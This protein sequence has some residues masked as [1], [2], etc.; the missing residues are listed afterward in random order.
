MREWGDGNGAF[1]SG[2]RGMQLRSLV[3]VSLLMGTVL[4]ASAEKATVA[5]LEQIIAENAA[6]TRPAIQHSMDSDEIADIADSNFLSDDDGRLAL[7]LAGIELEE[8]LST[9]SLYRL[10]GRYRLGS[11]AQMALQQIADRSAL[12]KLPPSEQMA[13]AA[14]DDEAQ[15]A[16]LNAAR[17]YVFGKLSHLP[18]FVATRTTTTFVDA[19]TPLRLSSPEAAEF[20]RSDMVQQEITFRD[21]KEVLLPATGALKG[22]SAETSTAFESRGEFG[23]QA[24]V[25]LMDVQ[26]G[27]ISFDHW[28]DTPGGIGAVYQYSVPRTNS[29][30]EVTDHCE[31]ESSFH[32]LP[33]YH[34]S[35]AIA[36]QSG[37][38]LRI[39]LEA[40][41]DKDDPVSHVASVIEYGPVLIGN[42][43]YL[44]PLRSLTFMTQKASGCSQHRRKLQKPIS[45]FN[46]TIFSNYHR[47][48]SS[49]TIIYGEVD[50]NAADA[51]V[52]PNQ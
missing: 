19:P 21:G 5:N 23:T 40:D 39:T 36:P 26:A 17:D 47:F 49:S 22:Q 6:T 13:R 46:R 20:H 3:F 25:L 8:R 29:H 42:R 14:P 44:C 15:R 51:A 35:I 37:A 45:M 43:R 31:G 9:L 38:I 16:M 4:P 41:S 52:H 18:D 1:S 28:E 12:L 34:G 11:R 7:Q 33:G 48:G 30:D 24:A 10:A 27:S 50:G 2:G 32:D